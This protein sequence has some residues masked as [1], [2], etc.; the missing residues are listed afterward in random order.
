V[1]SPW[2]AWSAGT[3]PRALARRI[4]SAHASFVLGARP[5]RSDERQVRE[6][7]LASWRRCAALGVDPDAAGP[8]PELGDAELGDYRRD[9]PLAAA[10][11]L[12]RRLLVADAVECDLVVAVADA[13][14]RLLWVEGSAPL[15]ARAER[16][17][18]VAGARWDEAHAGTNAPGLA[19]ATEHA[20]Q[21]FGGEHF[22][23]AVQPW[24]C[25]AAPV[26]DPRTGALVGVIDV[27][28]G[29]AVA[30]PQAL[31]IVRA[32]AAAVE[33]ELQVRGPAAVPA[34]PGPDRAARPAAPVGGWRLEVLGRDEARVTHAGSSR[35]LSRRHSEIALLLSEHP[36]GLS[37]EQ[38]DVALHLHDSALVTVR[39]EMSRLRRLLGE[40]VLASRPY[41]WCGAWA[42]DAG[43]VRELLRRGRLPAAV[44]AYPGAMLPGSQAPAVVTARAE[45][46][47]HLRRALIGGADASTLLRFARSAEGRLDAEVWRAAQVALGPRWP[48]RAEVRAHLGLL[49]AALR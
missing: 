41:R 15:R 40:E 42:S 29:D 16:V 49:E 18:F 17:G 22:A 30:A 28:G 2:L 34:S 45:L 3:D 5:G 37:A 32:V 24:S 25:S 31:A 33:L 46:H 19:L 35:T 21:V 13:D 26:R 39:A 20:V 9:H 44:A 7:V 11:P 6:V 23:L 4:R 14:G 8:I 27:T 38:L 36:E 43:A 47:E 10:M 1:S 48:E 12:V